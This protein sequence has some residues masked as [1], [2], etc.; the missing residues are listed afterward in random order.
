M[1][2]QFDLSTIK[3]IGA[4]LGV[5]GKLYGNYYRF[6]LKGSDTSRQLAIEIHPSIPIGK[7]VGSL[8]SV[9]T[10][11]SHLQ[12]QHCSGIVVSE[13]L[14]EVTFVAEHAGK[15]SG[16]IIEKEGGCSMYTNVDRSI[17]SGDF[18]K[19]GPEVMMSSIAL[20]LTEMILPEE[21]DRPISSE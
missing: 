10:A 7:E 5:E 12:M 18:T 16:L 11:T 21:F 20:S 13:M 17:L 9:F 8:V 14:G 15:L 4:I 6:E 1:N 2:F 3:Q 19:L